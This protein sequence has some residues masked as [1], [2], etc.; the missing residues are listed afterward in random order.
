MTD[1][2]NSTN[3]IQFCMFDSSKDL[4]IVLIFKLKEVDVTV[5]LYVSNFGAWGSKWCS[6]RT[7]EQIL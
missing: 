6:I 5:R 7:R 2:A 1:V 3:H 4:I